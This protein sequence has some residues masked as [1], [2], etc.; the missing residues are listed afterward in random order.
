[1]YAI[2]KTP[3]GV[4][5]TFQQ[6]VDSEEMQRW[7][8]EAAQLLPSLAKGFGMLVDNRQLR[9][10]GMTPE[11]QKILEQ[12]Q[13]SYK[14]HG[15]LRSCVVLQSASASMQL[16]QAARATAI[17][18]SE[19]CLNAST[20][21]DWEQIAVRWI[22]EGIEPPATAAVPADRPMTLIQRPPQ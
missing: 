21:P 6:T 22:R 1:M 7:A 3:F 17:S 13:A 20:T 9:P 18:G 10:G 4:K 12:M 5:F 2:S 14:A 8:E 11:A 19:R 15:M 16:E